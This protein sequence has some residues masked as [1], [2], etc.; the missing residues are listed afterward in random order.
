M[1]EDLG[2]GR[3]LRRVVTSRHSSGAPIAAELAR[4]K[5]CASRFSAR[6]AAASKLTGLVRRICDWRSRRMA[7][8]SSMGPRT[9]SSTC[10]DIRRPRTSERSIRRR[11]LLHR[12]S[13]R[14]GSAARAG[15][16]GSCGPGIIQHRDDPDGRS[17]RCSTTC[18][19]EVT[20]FGALPWTWCVIWKPGRMSVELFSH[21]LTPEQK[22]DGGDMVQSIDLLQRLCRVQEALSHRS[23]DSLQ[24]SPGP[25]PLS[26]ATAR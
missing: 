25:T 24:K 1:I 19:V 12:E 26:G 5:R 14:Q 18:R 11:W 23:A 15:A 22:H 16:D 6:T 21:R 13:R 10:T 3:P 2:I 20:T 4:R 8:T 17:R 9:T 7:R